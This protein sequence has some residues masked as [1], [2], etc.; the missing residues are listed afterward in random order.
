VKHH[1][2]GDDRREE[3]TAEAAQWLAT[4]RSC[5]AV[6]A[7]FQRSA[8]VL[9]GPA[10]AEFLLFDRAFPRAV[11]HNLDNARDLLAR[12][13]EGDPPAL[14]RASWQRLDRLRGS[15]LQM[16][17]P[18]VQELG[19]HKVLTTI[20][21][22]TASLCE[23]I[24]TDYLGPNAEDLLHAARRIRSVTPEPMSQAQTA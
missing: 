22:D 9:S 20:V 14:V 23:S 16:S 8:N 4:L 17:G 12:L 1:S 10:V 15:L 11:L 2:L 18:V 7:F 24:H 5:S 19:L 21:D 13:G 6:D 3:S